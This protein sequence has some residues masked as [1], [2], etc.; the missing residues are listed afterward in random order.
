MDHRSHQHHRMRRYHDVR[1]V[2]I[3]AH[4]G[5]QLSLRPTIVMMITNMSVVMTYD[6]VEMTKR[7]SRHV[8]HLWCH[9][10]LECQRSESA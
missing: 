5:A 9:S 2:Y 10:W 3:S 1:R 7:W 4:R 8:Q 6:D